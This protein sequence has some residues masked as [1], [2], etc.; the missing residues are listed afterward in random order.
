M[1]SSDV[2]DFKSCPTINSHILEP[3][4]KMGVGQKLPVLLELVIKTSK[5]FFLRHVLLVNADKRT[6]RFC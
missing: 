5:M 1:F 2:H 3:L 4:K 6:T